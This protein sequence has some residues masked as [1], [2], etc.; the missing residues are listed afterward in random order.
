MA[1]EQIVL[2]GE[3]AARVAPCARAPSSR[4]RRH[5]ERLRDRV[6]RHHY[7]ASKRQRDAAWGEVARRLAHE[8]KNR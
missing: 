3:A 8:I 4:R 2:R 7:A 6:R 1:G 5:A